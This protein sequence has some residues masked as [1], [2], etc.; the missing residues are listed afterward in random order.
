M[1][2]KTCYA[3]PIKDSNNYRIHLWDDEGYKTLTWN[4][5]AYEECDDMDSDPNIRGLRHESLRK[6][7]KWSRENER[8]H[9]HDIKPY[10]RFL[11][12]KYGTDDEPSTSHKE[13]F[14]DIHR[15]GSEQSR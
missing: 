3:Q 4:Y 15:P 12:D 7:T 11:I 9:F 2:Y 14:F 10:Q 13:I 6:V 5:Y 1:S 8:L